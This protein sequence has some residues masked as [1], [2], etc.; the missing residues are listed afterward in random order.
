[1]TT[2]SS[3]LQQ[4]CGIEFGGLRTVSAGI[5]AVSRGN[6]RS[7]KELGFC[8]PQTKGLVLEQGFVWLSKV[9]VH[10]IQAELCETAGLCR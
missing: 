6:Y 7:V 2:A 10:E 3:S 1:M 8:K 9:Y 5:L 4:L